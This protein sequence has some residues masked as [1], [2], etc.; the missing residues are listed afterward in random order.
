MCAAGVLPPMTKWKHFGPDVL[1]PACSQSSRS[2]SSV[3]RAPL[4]ESGSDS[5]RPASTASE[6][7]GSAMRSSVVRTMSMIEV[8]SSSS[9]L[10]IS[11]RMLGTVFM[12]AV[13]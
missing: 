11:G 1:P 9:R 13:D 5:P 6:P 10:C 4:P 3:S 12:A 7:G 2:F 8:P